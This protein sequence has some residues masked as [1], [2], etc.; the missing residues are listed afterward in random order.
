MAS[1]SACKLSYT[2]ISWCV[3]GTGSWKLGNRSVIWMS[4][5]P[6]PRLL[7][8]LPLGFKWE[9]LLSHMACSTAHCIRSECR[10][11][12][13]TTSRDLLRVWDQRLGII[14]STSVSFND[15]APM[16]RSLYQITVQT[17]LMLA[18]MY[19]QHVCYVNIRCQLS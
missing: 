8:L 18:S 14:Y 17:N 10:R 2:R 9:T 5:G 11:L 3:M 16:H 4:T 13:L 7:H 15:S 19:T 6:S 1:L 12:L